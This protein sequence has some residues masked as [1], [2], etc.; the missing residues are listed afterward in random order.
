MDFASL[1]ANTKLK[2]VAV[3]EKLDVT[4]MRAICETEEDYRRLMEETYF[5]VRSAVSISQPTDTLRNIGA[6]CSPS[7][8]LQNLYHCHLLLH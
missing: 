6:S 5:L 7:L 3:S 8:L 2:K 4:L 1:L